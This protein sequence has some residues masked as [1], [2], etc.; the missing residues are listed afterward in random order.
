MNDILN[1]YVRPDGTR[2]LSAEEKM[3][4]GR[5]AIN[6]L[7]RYRERKAANADSSEL[8]GLN[9]TLQ[10]NMPYFGYGYIKDKAELVPYI[11][12][13]FYAFRVMVGLG[14][15]FILLFAVIIFLLYKRDIQKY[16][17]LLWLGVLSLPLAYIASEAGWI[18]AEMGRQPWAIQDL[19][20]TCAAVSDISAGSVAVTFFIFLAL[21][22]TLLAVEVNIL[23]KQ[24]KKGPEYTA[25]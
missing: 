22:T 6:T 3:E 11:P 15:Y 16:G 9:D 20:P 21:F 1:G 25:N 12:L 23:C 18:V 17:Y 5:I 10:A 7:A 13:C 24:I 4:K 2:E 19:L 14:A 8:A